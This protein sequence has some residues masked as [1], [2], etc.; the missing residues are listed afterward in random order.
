[1]TATMVAPPALPAPPA[2][3]I[4]GYRFELV[5]LLAQW[6]I[7]IVLAACWFGPAL[8]V[9]VVSN[10]SSLPSDTV[11]GRWMGQSGWAGP[12]VVLSFSC[13]WVLPLVTSVVA[14]DVF[15]AEDRIGTWR[16]LLVAVRSPRRIFVA[17]ALASL[18]VLLL[19]VAGLAGSSIAGGLAAVGNRPLAGLDGHLLAPGDAA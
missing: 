15:A 13:T 10:Q 9:A 19:L 2:P 14:G 11:F 16:Y 1:M 12:L 18:T 4:N 8:L 5:K 3:L 17:K 7:R 6:R